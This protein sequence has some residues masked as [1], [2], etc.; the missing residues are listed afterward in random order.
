M[1]FKGQKL[2]EVLT[3]AIVVACAVVGFLYGYA[4]QDF[5]G[6]MSIF[7]GGVAAAFLVGVPDWPIYNKHPV[8]FLPP[9]ADRQT[10]RGSGSGNGSSGSSS[11]KRKGKKKE[12]SWVNLWGAF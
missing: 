7:G 2:A 9:K 11:G 1:D 8:K 12:A 10:G 6:M 3:M 5:H 4:A